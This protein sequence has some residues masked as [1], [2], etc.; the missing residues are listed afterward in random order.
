MSKDNSA[1]NKSKD[2]SFNRKKST[3]V[4]GEK[5]QP[6]V[7]TYGVTVKNKDAIEYII[8]SPMRCGFLLVLC[9]LFSP[10]S[11][12]KIPF[13]FYILFIGILCISV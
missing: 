8:E 4:F 13:L 7:T 1:R 12:L 6:V 10:K 3:S 11:Y 9:F 5:G 2:N